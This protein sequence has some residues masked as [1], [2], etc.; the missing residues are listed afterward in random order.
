MVGGDRLLHHL[1]GVFFGLDIGEPLLELGNPAI[2]QLA[3]T[4]EFA[5]ALCV[6]EFDAQAVEFAFQLLG[7][8]ELVLLRAP[9]RG[10]SRRF[11]LEVGEFLFQRLQPAL[12]A[13]I[14]FLLQRLLLDLQP[15]DFPIHR[16]E[17]FRLGIDLH[18]QPRRRLVHQIDG[19]VGQ[20]AVGDI[21]VRQRGRRHQRGIGDADAVV[22]LVFVLQAAQDRNS[23]LDRRLR[24][25]DRLEPAR[26]RRILFDVLAIFVERGRADTMQFATRQRGLQQIRGVHR[27]IGLAGTDQRV[28]L[29]DEQDDRA[30]G[31][32]DFLQHGFQPLLELAAVFCTR[33]QRAHVEREQLLVFQAFRHVAVEDPQRQ[34]FDDR[35][36]AD[37]GLADQ[38]RIVLGAAGKH[39]DGA[40]D[41]LVTAND[42]IELAVARGLGQVAGIF[43]QRVIGVLRRGAIRGAALA[44]RFDRRI[45][46]LRRNATF[47]QDGTGLAALLQG[48]AEQEPL[49]GD[50]AVSGLFGRLLRR[51]ERARQFGGEVN[52]PGAASGYFRQLV[53]RIL[54]GLE[55]GAGVPAGTVN[56]TA[57][58]P[59]A[60]IEQHFQQSVAAKIADGR[61][62][63][64]AT[65]QTG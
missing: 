4:L 29:V 42:R 20:E 33:N 50:K 48:Q 47:A 52:L 53:E 21:A 39:L 63:R 41:F 32:G 26:Q 31:R 38:H 64:Q 65:A 6:G 36:L 3:R 46:V 61:R 5:A 43:L 44:Q 9:A 58:K 17:L 51:V 1:A 57:G 15:D 49:D 59:L 45:Q 8:G 35:G 13:G 10:E 7:V 62:A 25:E 34:P 40:A 60:V 12:R 22:L 16:I 56:Q 18:L 54:G 27:A 23:V 37:A 19:L 28:H 30:L 11:L 2:G 24:H 55:D 14:A